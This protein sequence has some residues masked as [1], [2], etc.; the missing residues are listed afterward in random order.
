MRH[1]Y[2]DNNATTRVDPEVVEAML[3]FFSENYGNPSSVHKPGR[4]ARKAVDNARAL[5]ASLVNCDPSEVIFTSGGSEAINTVRKGVIDAGRETA[6]HCITTKVEHSAVINCCR[7]LEGKGHNITWLEVDAEGTLTPAA[8]EAAITEKTALISVMYGNNETGVIFPVE[9]VG[10]IAS[11]RGIPF[12][13]DSVQAVGKVPINFKDLPADFLTV[14][15]HKFHAPKGMGAL[16]VRKG[17]EL[18]PLIHGGSQEKHRRGGT[19]NVPGIVG[20]GA[21]CEIA[22]KKLESESARIRALRLRFEQRVMELIP[23]A[24]LNGHAEKRLPNTSNISFIGANAELLLTELDRAGVPVSAGSACTSG[25]RTIS[26]VLG[27]MGLDDAMARSAIRFS[28]GRENTEDDLDYVL[29]LLPDMVEKL[30]RKKKTK[31]CITVT[32]DAN[33][34]FD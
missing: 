3:P 1:V 13:C 2:L 25:N 31:P 6:R 11:R 10:E 8:V 14:S 5:V 28:F 34:V 18:G 22:R 21:A 33:S 15:G 27:A 20:F 24:K 32:T 7:Y 4:T 29:D 23:D 19:E 9:E 26:H 16:I 12:L 17:F 30:R